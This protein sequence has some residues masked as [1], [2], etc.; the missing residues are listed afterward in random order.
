MG[1]FSR[2][3]NACLP[4]VTGDTPSPCGQDATHYFYGQE[5]CPHCFKR[6]MRQ[7]KERE[8]IA[9]EREEDRQAELIAE[10]VVAKL[11]EKGYSSAS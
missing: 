11:R 6:R 4:K 10:K 3:R 9:K 5:T 7:R 8:R 2:L 1:L